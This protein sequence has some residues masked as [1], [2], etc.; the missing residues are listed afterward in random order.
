[1]SQICPTILATNTSDYSKQ[2]EKVNFAPRLQVDVMDGIFTNSKSLELADIPIFQPGQV[3]LHVMFQRPSDFFDEFI[4]LKP[5]MVIV[6]AES[7][8][9]VPFLAHKLRQ[10][11][12]K[13]GLSLLQDTQV[14]EVEYLFPHIQH[15]LIFS[16]NLGHFGGRADLSLLTKIEQ[17]KKMSNYLEYGWDGGA[18]FENVHKLASGGV[19]VINVGGA[20]QNAPDALETYKS[21]KSLMD[22]N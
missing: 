2:L 10:N 12:I 9:D 19:D 14:E 6:Q 16:G 11:N 5:A 1:M 22:T 15:L 8:C 18:S 17:A 4:R 7:D 20:I 21:L 13:T 3:D